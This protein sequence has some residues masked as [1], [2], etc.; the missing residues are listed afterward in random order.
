MSAA[1]SPAQSRKPWRQL[2]CAGS[3]P[4][5]RL[6]LALAAPRIS[7]APRRRRPCRRRAGPARP[8]PGAAAWRRA[9]RRRPAATRAAAPA[10]RRRRCRRRERRAR[11]RRRSRAAASSTWTK[12]KVP[13]PLPTIG[14]GASAR[15]S[16]CGAAAV[17]VGAR[18][19]EPAAAQDEP[20][21]PVGARA[22]GA[23][24]RRSPP[25][26]APKRPGAS[27]NSGASSSLTQSPSG[28]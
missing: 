13:V 12:E 15:P 2:G 7:D 27:A 10:R 18:P 1:A 23:R 8:G 28:R 9:P 4:S 16:A 25:K 24:A 3:Q 19:V 11:A 14:S 22:P 6:A 26:A 20:L 5:S 17:V 21:D